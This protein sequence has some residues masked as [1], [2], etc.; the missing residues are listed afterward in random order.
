M[1]CTPEK[2]SCQRPEAKSSFR[3]AFIFLSTEKRDALS[4][5][6]GYCRAVDDAVDEPS[7]ISPAESVR[8]WREETERLYAGKPTHPITRA[9]LEPV[10]AFDIHKEHLLMVLN[11]VAMD[12][13]V[14]RYETLADLQ[15]YMYGVACAV[16]HLCL[17][18]F[19][20]AET[21]REPFCANL[22]YAVQLT[23]I[24]RDVASDAQR[25]RIYFPL[26][27]LRRFNVAPEDILNRRMTPGILAL[28]QF[29]TERALAFYEANASLVKPADKKRLFPCAVIAEVYKALLLK[30]AKKG[31]PVFEGKVKLSK[32]D[33]AKALFRAWRKS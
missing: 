29:E 7:D 25:G 24:I 12:I 1:S 21:D 4:A 11:G 20:C 17:G 16:A 23:N 33:K 6:Y 19:G 30:I 27:D 10:A 18:I 8:F 2:E 22:G 5:V 15:K 3:P 14:F 26:E 28:L 31:Y 13:D 9:L 32:F